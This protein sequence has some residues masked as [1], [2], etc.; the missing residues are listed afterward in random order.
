MCGLSKFTSFQVDCLEAHND[1][2]LRHGVHRI[3]LDKKLCKYAQE[4]A[5]YLKGCNLVAPSKSTTYGEN[6]FFKCRDRKV[7]PDPFEP[8]Q[9][10]YEESSKIKCGTNYPA[11][12]VMHYAQ[13][14]WAETKF[15]GVGYA[16][17]E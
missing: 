17:N 5:D 14:V 4:W 1:Y 16:I 3:E 12:D 11:K 15:M 9:S 8:V 13:V 6:I 2:R 7:F 10:W